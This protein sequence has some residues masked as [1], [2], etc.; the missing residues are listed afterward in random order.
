MERGRWNRDSFKNYL[1]QRNRE[2]EIALQSDTEFVKLQFSCNAGFLMIGAVALNQI[3]GVDSL[4]SEILKYHS[5]YHELNRG[6]S[7]QGI[8]VTMPK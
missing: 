5:I 4:K 3:D 2:E 8:V 7:C 6:A 1:A